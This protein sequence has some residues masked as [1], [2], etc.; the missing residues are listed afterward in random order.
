MPQASRRRRF[1]STLPARGATTGRTAGHSPEKISIHAP[2]T[3]SDPDVRGNRT[4]VPISIHAPRTGS[5]SFSCPSARAYS[6]FN[7][8]SPHGER[9]STRPRCTAHRAFQS[10]LP[11]RGAT[12]GWK[13]S[14]AKAS[15]FQ[16][17][18]PARGATKTQRGSYHFL[19]FQS[20][21][22]A[23]GATT[24]ISCVWRAMLFQSTL[25]ARGATRCNHD[26]A[27][28]GKYFNPRSPHGERR[29][30]TP[31]IA[32]MLGFQSTLPARGA[33]TS[34]SGLNGRMVISIHA[35]RTGS[36]CRMPSSTDL[37]EISIHAPRTGSDTTA[38]S[39]ASS[40]LISIHA[41]R[42]GSDVF[43]VPLAPVMRIFQSTLPARGATGRRPPPGSVGSISI[44]APRTGSDQRLPCKTARF[45]CISIHAP[46]TGSDEF[47]AYVV[48]GDIIFQSTLP[49]RGA[50][51]RAS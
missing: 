10:T 7:P 1:Q 29:W 21:L 38:A 34:I 45:L 11:A 41:P 37:I 2:R 6:N 43:P 20:T 5:D 31:Q 4:T 24:I 23:R 22:P 42:T 16:S 39:T 46:R 49:A 48:Y 44:H 36:D 3:G 12:G 14:S 35:P 30:K 8:R 28:A 51:R 15:A 13:K 27:N 40:A 47:D 9:Q 50:T 33:T 25:P 18:L 17:T 32:A 26:T 19:L